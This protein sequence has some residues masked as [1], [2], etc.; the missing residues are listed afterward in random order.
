MFGW[1]LL[2]ASIG[3]ALLHTPWWWVAA[4]I[5]GLWHVAMYQKYHSRPW[6]RMHYPLMRQYATA[7]GTVMSRAPNQPAGATVKEALALLVAGALGVSVPD[8][9]TYVRLQ[10]TRADGALEREALEQEILRRRRPGDPATLNQAL[11]ELERF[12]K[13]EDP[14]MQVRLIIA[15]LIE[16]RHGA[17]ARAEYL[18]EVAA[19]Q[20]T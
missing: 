8:A 1:L 7:A 18:Y 3:L 20:A 17:A 2:L 14:A 16:Q 19:G 5:L 4:A 9:R 12:F 13:N 10:L 15:G 6:R 11:D